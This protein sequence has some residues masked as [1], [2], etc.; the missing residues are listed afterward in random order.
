MPLYKFI[1][2]MPQAYLNFPFSI[3]LFSIFHFQFLLRV[4]AWCK[5]HPQ[6]TLAAS[7]FCGGIFVP[8]KRASPQ[9][10]LRK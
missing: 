2:T 8:R 4:V 3:F 10:T 9:F 5:K 7:G 6:G 1:D